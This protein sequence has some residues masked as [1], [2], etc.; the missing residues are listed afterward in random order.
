MAIVYAEP[1]YSFKNI[2]LSGLGD[3]IGK[4]AENWI[5][6][7]QMAKLKAAEAEYFQAMQQY[8]QNQPRIGAPEGQTETVQTAP[9][10]PKPFMASGDRAADKGGFMT[11]P[12]FEKVAAKPGANPYTFM[13]VDA[14]G[15]MNAGLQALK[16]S[17]RLAYAPNFDLQQAM[18]LSQAMDA[19]RLAEFYGGSTARKYAAQDKLYNNLAGSDNPYLPLLAP[20]AYLDDSPGKTGVEAAVGYGKNTNEARQ[21]EIY[22]LDSE[23]DYEVGKGQIAADR[24]RTD[25]ME[26]NSRREAGRYGTQPDPWKTTGNDLQSRAWTTGLTPAEAQEFLVAY[27]PNLLEPRSDRSGNLIRP[28]LLDVAKQL[29]IRIIGQPGQ[30][31]TQMDPDLLDAM[32]KELGLGGNGLYDRFIL[33]NEQVRK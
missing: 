21:N 10:A 27:H 29:G 14:V 30:G 23:R 18:F 16:K 13:P 22:A 32:L 17:G 4:V 33:G 12:V 5:K 8:A 9:T 6:R 26:R 2:A 15:M 28:K 24:Y 31:T 20:A 19:S 25:S 7:G 11:A 3:V 1:R